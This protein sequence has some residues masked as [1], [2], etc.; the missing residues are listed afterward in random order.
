[1]IKMKKVLLALLSAA[2][3]SCGTEPASDESP[4]TTPPPT[5]QQGQR[6]PKS[7]VDLNGQEVSYMADSVAMNGYLVYDKNIEG[8]RPGV[9]VVHEWW[10]HNN[11]ARQSAEYLAS[12]GYTALAVDMYGNGQTADH[13]SD[14]GSFAGAVMSDFD[15]ATARFLEAKKLLENHP[16]VTN[17]KI[18]AVGYCFG[19][20]VVLNMARQGVDLDGV[21]SIHGSLGAAV[22]ATDTIQ[23]KILVLTGEDDPFVPG[24]A[25]DAFASEMTANG[26]D[27]KLIA[28]PGAVHAFSNPEATAKGE[29]FDLP[30]AYNA[31]ADS[32]SKEE[33]KSFFSMSFE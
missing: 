10:G 16:T 18:G 31:E 4:E 20:G 17:D 13:P 27:Y 30:L 24:T 26:A 12:L 15:G 8:Q 33:M 2:L 11:H 3:F 19:G 9:L 22:E 21:V 29:E 5:E 6:M 32:L 1:M 28:Y 25:R 7:G 14:A 23:T